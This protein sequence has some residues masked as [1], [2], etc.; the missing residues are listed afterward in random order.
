MEIR[1]G[2]ESKAVGM[3]K[4]YPF[5]EWISWKLWSMHNIAF[6]CF[7]FFWGGA[8]NCV[9]LS[10]SEEARSTNG[11][12]MVLAY[13]SATCFGLVLGPQSSPHI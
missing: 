10:N 9:E 4:S 1:V 5:F 13:A 7:V 2:G 8:G 6:S 12:N 3:H 11:S